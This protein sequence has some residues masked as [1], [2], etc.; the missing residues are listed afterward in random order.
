MR[1]LHLANFHSTNIG[2]GALI[3]GTERV[4]SEDLGA[5]VTFLGEPWD[6]YTALRTRRFD[7]GFVDRVNGTDGLLVGAAV[8]LDSRPD[9]THAG[10]RVDLPL[11]LWRRV[12]KS[13]SFYAISYRM[14]PYQRFHH[15]EQFRRTMHYILQNPRM[16]FSVR[17]DGS[18]AWIEALLGHQSDRI[19]AVPDPALYVPTVDSWHPE[20]AEDRTNVLVS[21]NNEDEVYRFGGRLREQAWK[22]LARRVDEKHLLRAWRY[23]P[24][25]PRRKRRVLQQLAAALERL[26][27]EWDVNIILC[28]HYFDD[29]KIIS[30]FVSVCSRRLAYQLMVS[31]GLLTAPRAPY[32]Y[33]L[34]AKVDVAL[35]MRVH[36]MTPA[37][38]LG[39]PCVA[40]VSQSRMSAFLADAGLEEFG[41]DLFDASLA[42]RVYERLTHCLKA[43]DQVRGRF[44]AVRAAMRQRSA[45]YHQS[46]APLFSSSARSAFAPVASGV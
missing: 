5:D 2:N 13:V 44:Q 14:W 22:W 37:I 40:L 20:L 28:P 3:Y 36:S 31:S 32:F 41:V 29:Y 16:R 19:T 39:T 30:E 38:G 23:A 42:E 26:T 27:R 18:K 45:A 10:M 24:D 35:S 33:D 21:L 34:Y 7:A 46:L 8:T 15:I 12:S 9:F 4:L 11:E 43:R 1:L 25:W 17:N 6:D